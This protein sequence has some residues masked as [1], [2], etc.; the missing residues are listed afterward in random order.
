LT[1]AFDLRLPEPERRRAA[2][3]AT[4]WNDLLYVPGPGFTSPLEP[5]LYRSSFVIVPTEG[6]AVRV[7]SFVVPAFGSELCRLR[8]EP[9]VSFRAENLGSFF[10]PPR[11]GVVYAMSPDRKTGAARPPDR[12]SWSYQGPSLQPRLERAGRVRL[13]RERVTGGEGDSVFSWVADRGLVIAGVDDQ[14]MLLLAGPDSSE[15]A[16]LVTGLG[17]YR[18]LVDRAAPETPGAT[19]KELL[20]YGD[21]DDALRVEVDMEPL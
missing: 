20:G 21:R 7:S 1:Q 2:G 11:R 16:T 9:L 4:E 5:G 19:V 12:Q 17:F 15:Q 13:I 18:A 6:R 8:L 14:D 10:E 3:L